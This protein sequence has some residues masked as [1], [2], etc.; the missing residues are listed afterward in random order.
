MAKVMI[1]V[2][3]YLVCALLPTSQIFI[4]HLFVYKHSARH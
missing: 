3:T 2:S 1:E 4:E